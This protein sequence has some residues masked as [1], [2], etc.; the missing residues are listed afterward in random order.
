MNRSFKIVCFIS[1]LAVIFLDQLSKYII[2]AKIPVQGIFLIS[3]DKLKISLTPFVN[4]H[5]AFGLNAPAFI[6]YLLFTAAL[7]ALIFLMQKY[8]QSDKTNLLFS[9]LIISA[10]FSNFLDRLRL[11]GV[12]DFFSIGL[13]GFF[14]PAFNLADALITI[15]IFYLLVKTIIKN[16]TL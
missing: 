1:G 10:A 2:Q 14:W 15:G 11:G 16:K 5:L 12:Y 8:F 9:L 3:G 13:N 4:E 6:I 7:V